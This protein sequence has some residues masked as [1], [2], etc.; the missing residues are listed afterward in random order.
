[1]VIANQ[2]G[3][4]TARLWT[5]RFNPKIICSSAAVDVGGW[6]RSLGLG[7]YEA[8]GAGAGG[9]RRDPHLA[10]RLRAL[11]QP[12]QIV[13]A[14]VTRRLIGDLFRLTD[15]GARPRHVGSS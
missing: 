8:L 14:G 6:L 7:Q 3:A 15:L 2:P 5:G 11:A 13:L 12:G 9:G 1:L 4:S 10:T